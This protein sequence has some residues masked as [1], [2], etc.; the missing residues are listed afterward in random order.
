MFV[1][2][3]PA[4]AVGAIYRTPTTASIAIQ[5]VPQHCQNVECRRL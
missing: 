3:A 1:V 2:D 5:N 4:H